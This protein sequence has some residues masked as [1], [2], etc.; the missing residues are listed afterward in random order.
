MEKINKEICTCECHKKGFSVL[1]MTSCCDLTYEK[2]INEDGSIDM[3]T[4][5]NKMVYVNPFFKEDG[6]EAITTIEGLIN[7]MGSGKSY[8]SYLDMVKEKEEHIKYLNDNCNTRQARRK[9]EREA[10]KLNKN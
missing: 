9:R 4:Y 8:K 3:E 7:G 6:E 5:N 2:Y 1:H 10:K